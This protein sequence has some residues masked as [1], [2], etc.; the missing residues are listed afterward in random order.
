MGFEVV[1]GTF[2]DLFFMVSQ[3]FLF[4]FLVEGTDKDRVM[5]GEIEVN[6]ASA[7]AFTSTGQPHSRLP[8]SA[9]SLYDITFLRVLH[10]FVLELSIVL[11]TDHRRYDGRNLGMFDEYQRRVYVTSYH[12][13]SAGCGKLGFISDGHAGHDDDL[14]RGQFLVLI[15]GGQDDLSALGVGFVHGPAAVSERVLREPLGIAAFLGPLRPRMPV[16]VQ[17]DPDHPRDAAAAAE[18]RGAGI[19]SRRPDGGE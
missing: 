13:S 19:G 12:V 11:I 15:E 16:A 5:F 17:A 3:I 8:K 1:G 18:L 9:C 2:E 14:F 4:R 10:Q 6:D 7:A